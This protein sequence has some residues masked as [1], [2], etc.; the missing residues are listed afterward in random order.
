MTPTIKRNIAIAACTVNIV[1]AAITVLA[2]YGGTVNPEK[3]TIP[4]ILAMTFPAW[5]VLL[6][7]MLIADMIFFRK[8]AFIPLITIIASLS[9]ILSFSPL[10]ILPRKLSPQQ[11]ENS[12]TLMSYN[13][14]DFTDFTAEPPD[15]TAPRKRSQDYIDEMNAGIL[16]QTLSYILQSAP[17]IGCF[18]ECP[19]ARSIPRVHVSEEQSDSL[20]R[21]FPYRTGENGEDVYSRFPLE[22]VALRQPES[23]YCWFG[24]AIVDIMGHRTLVVSVHFQSIGLNSQDRELFYQ[25]TEGENTTKVKQV[26]RQLLGKLSYAFKE[27]A[28]QARMLREQIDSLNVR[29]VIIAGDFNDIPDCYAIRLIARDDFKSA[30]ATA[31]CGPTYTYYGDR[32]FFN[33]D[34]VLY[35]GDM[36]AVKYRRVK[37]GRSDHY[38]VEVRFI[39]D[40]PGEN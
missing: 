21:L 18:Q 33:I 23:E 22:R 12:F 28:K 16:N 11:E 8:M 26:K 29:N 20:C 35:R 34:H 39:W 17:D 13:V 1:L 2:A 14:F 10:H 38:P 31:G 3:T 19:G 40:T 37:A 7:L 36:E 5:A 30:F 27:R 25:L 6:V 4:A 24:G 32:F 15:S 9:P